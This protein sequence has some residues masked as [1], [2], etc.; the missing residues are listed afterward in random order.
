MYHVYVYVPETHVEEVKTAM[1]AVGAGR[2]GNY[3]CCAWQTLGEGQYRPREGAE[4]FIGE[5]DRI[6]RVS[7]FRVEMIC[8]DAVLADVV[9][10]MRQ[11]HPYEEPAFGALRLADTA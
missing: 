2:I 5:L 3:D 11:A 1:F 7:E 9:A 8:E 6:E 4:P 10:A